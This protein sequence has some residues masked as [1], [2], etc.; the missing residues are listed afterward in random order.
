MCVCVRSIRNS[1]CYRKGDKIHKW[2]HKILLDSG[3][4]QI[5]TTGP[6]GRKELVLPPLSDFLISEHQQRDQ[7]RG[8]DNHPR[9]YI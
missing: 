5:K 7:I 1:C 4:N 3:G 2:A 9:A 8:K 6:V